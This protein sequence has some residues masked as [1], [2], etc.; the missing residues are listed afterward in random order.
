MALTCEQQRG[1]L[2]DYR[3]TQMLKYK[4]KYFGLVDVHFN[5]KKI[6]VNMACGWCCVNHIHVFKYLLTIDKDLH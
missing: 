3:H 1:I 4:T 6:F 2:I 5:R